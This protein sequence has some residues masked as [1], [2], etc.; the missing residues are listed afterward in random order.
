MTHLHRVPQP[1]DRLLDDPGP[2]DGCTC[3]GWRSWTSAVVWTFFTQFQTATPPPTATTT[4]PTTPPQ[5][6]TCQVTDTINAWN[7]GLT[8]SITI[9]NTQTTAI[10]DWSL[11]FT[12]AGGQ[13]ITSGWNADYSPT[14]G[15][16]TARSVSYDTGIAAGASVNIGFQ[17]THTGNTDAP[18]SFTLNGTACAVG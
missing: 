1:P 10:G 2:I 18:T 15:Q 3:D 17:A 5:S 12:L 8:S 14:S 16:V 6:G 11:E 13:T 7:T 9:T 4:P